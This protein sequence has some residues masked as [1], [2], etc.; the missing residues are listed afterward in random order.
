MISWLLLFSD[1]FSLFFSSSVSTFC[2][3]FSVFSFSTLLGSWVITSF[4]FSSIFSVFSSLFSII[5]DSFF[6]HLFASSFT[7]SI[8]SSNVSTISSWFSF[9]VFCSSISW[10]ELFSWAFSIPEFSSIC[11]FSIFA[12][13][14]ET[15]KIKINKTNNF[16]ILRIYM[17]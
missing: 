10:L 11:W 3:F 2:S 6:S 14:Q 13:P 1:W 15:T 9:W 5:S 16:F 7:K 8:I 4:E 17:I 12:F